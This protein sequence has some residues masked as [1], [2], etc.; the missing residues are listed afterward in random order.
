MSQGDGVK[1]NLDQCERKAFGHQ[2][3]EKVMFLGFYYEYSN[4]FLNGSS[5]VK[6]NL[7]SQNLVSIQLLDL[8]K[9]AEMFSPSSHTDAGMANLIYLNKLL[10]TP[11]LPF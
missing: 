7:I 11:V 9:E 6:L 10:I 1:L 8:H 3:K 2:Q 4:I 5:K